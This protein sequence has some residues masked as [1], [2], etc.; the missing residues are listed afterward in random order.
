MIGELL[1]SDAKDNKRLNVLL[2]NIAVLSC[3]PSFL[4]I[5]AP[6]P[7]AGRIDLQNLEFWTS[8]SEWRKAVKAERS[9]SLKIDLMHQVG[10]INQPD[11]SNV[12]N[13][14]R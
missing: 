10:C 1:L 12:L 13:K 6:V 11:A 14:T 8:S 2:K 5:F 9:E 4:P 7:G 3:Q